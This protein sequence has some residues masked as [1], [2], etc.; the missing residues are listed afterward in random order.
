MYLKY[1]LRYIE[2]VH[3][4]R[5][6]CPPGPGTDHAAPLGV[7]CTLYSVC[8]CRAKRQ[9]SNPCLIYHTF[10]STFQ[11]LQISMGIKKTFVN[12]ICLTSDESRSIFFLIK[13][14]QRDGGPKATKPS[15]LYSVTEVPS[16]SLSPSLPPSSLP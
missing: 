15:G 5:R 11:T 3:S 7:H 13:E 9:D 14:T 6:F 16:S 12:Y 1:T 2:V 4:I 10:V 8:T